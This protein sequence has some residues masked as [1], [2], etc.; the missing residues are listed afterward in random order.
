MQ[1][2]GGGFWQTGDGREPRGN[3]GRERSSWWPWR[4]YEGVCVCVCACCVRWALTASLDKVEPWKFLKSGFEAQQS[5]AP[6]ERTNR[7]GS[8]E[9]GSNCPR[10]VNVDLCPSGLAGGGGAG[11]QCRGMRR[12]EAKAGRWATPEPQGSLHLSLG[13]PERCPQRDLSGFRF[14]PSELGGVLLL[15]SLLYSGFQGLRSELQHQPSSCKANTSPPAVNQR[16]AFV[17]I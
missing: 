4:V 2:S 3:E 13:G 9:E 5:R 8:S 7:E 17:T 6:T 11:L 12:E 15:T 14:C 10:V 1:R 16:W